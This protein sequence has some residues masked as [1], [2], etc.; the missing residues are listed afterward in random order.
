MEAIDKVSEMVKAGFPCFYIYTEDELSVERQLRD[1]SSSFKDFPYKVEKWTTL[2]GDVDDFLEKTSKTETP[3]YFKRKNIHFYLDQPGI[4]QTIKDGVIKWKSQ[5]HKVFFLENDKKIPPEINRDITYIEFDLPNEQVLSAQVRYIQES[6]SEAG[7]CIDLK[8]E[9]VKILAKSALGL[10]TQQA[11]DAFSLSVARNQT[12]DPNIVTEVKAGEYLKSGLLELEQPLD[13]SSFQG[14]EHLKEY[15]Y[16]IKD[17]FFGVSKFNLPPPKGVLLIGPPGVG[18]SLASK[19]I[20]SV[21]NLM[22]LKCDLGKVKGMY[23]GESGRN[24]RTLINIAERMSPIVMRI[25]EI[26]KQLSGTGG[27]LDGGVAVE[28]LGSLLTWMQDSTAP[29]FRVAT[30][31]QVDTL[32]PELLRKGRFDE[33]FFLDLPDLDERVSIFEHHIFSRSDFQFDVNIAEQTNGWSGAEIEQIVIQSLRKYESLIN[34][35]IEE[36]DFQSILRVEISKTVP[37]SV[38]R[39]EDIDRIRQWA[40]DNGARMASENK[41]LQSKQDENRNGRRI[42]LNS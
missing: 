41:D 7:L 4:I 23:V 40:V 13:I 14:Y 34:T 38:I 6:A 27:N 42:M 35:Q 16:D 22:L 3:T 8:D 17:S 5:G 1:L 19:A 12:L 25:D 31:N 10:T 29:V 24:F 26:E 33:I 30:C 32:R 15:I 21:F 20:A 11:Q 28:L 36:S 9:D 18:K 2:T 39:K 37:L